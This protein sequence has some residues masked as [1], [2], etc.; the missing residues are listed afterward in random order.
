[1]HACARLRTNRMLH[2]R[3]GILPHEGT[4]CRAPCNLLPP[5]EEGPGLLCALVGKPGGRPI[6]DCGM[7]RFFFFVVGETKPAAVFGLHGSPA[8]SGEITYRSGANPGEQRHA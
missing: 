1:M 5:A 8:G 3:R 7:R 2:G 4:I 6:D